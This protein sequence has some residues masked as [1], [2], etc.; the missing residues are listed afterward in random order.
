MENIAILGAGTWGAALAKILHQNGNRVTLWSALQTEV[1]ALAQT[2]RHPHLPGMIFPGEIHLT[3]DLKDAVSGADIL[4]FAVAS[5]Y[6]RST[7]KNAAPFVR[8]GQIIVDVAKGLESVTHMTLTEVIADEIR[9][10]GIPLVA[11]SGPTHA[12]EVANDMPTAIVAASADLSAAKR[13]QAAFSGDVLRVYT[14]TD[15]KGVEICGA[16][17]NIIALAAGI[18]DGLGFGDNAK[19]AL[20]TR[21]MAEITRLG[22]KLGGRQRTFESLAGIGDL[23]VTCTSRHSRNNRAGHLIG[24]GKTPAEAVQEVGMVVEG[25]HALPAA[26]E[27]SEKHGVEMPL[28]SMVAEILRGDIAASKALGLLMAR[29][30]KNENE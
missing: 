13:I 26:I 19:A 11:L 17:K 5:P 15:I 21:G 1:E 10:P 6:V 28:C 8:D 12:E 25:I 2:G 14:N 23:I 29:E 18:S 9:T 16:L 27:L 4:V 3:T 24:Q 22:T 20:I 30:L 7:A